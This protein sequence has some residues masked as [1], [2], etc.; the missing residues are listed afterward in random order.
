MYSLI[1]EETVKR[2][3]DAAEEILNKCFGMLMEIKHASDTLGDAIMN[4]QLLL[5]DCLY[6][7]M[8]FY[9][10]LQAEKDFIISQ[11]SKWEQVLFKDAITTNAK[12]LKVVKEVITIGKTLGDAFSWFFYSKNRSE[13]DMHLEHPSTG[14]FVAGVGGKGEIEFIKNNQ[15]I[16]GLFVVYHGITDM[17]RVGDFSLYANGI[18][19]VGIGELKSQREGDRISVTANITSKVNIKTPAEAVGSELSFEERI[20][21]LAKS[22]PSLPKQMEAQDRLMKIKECERSSNFYAD[23]EYDVV[24]SLSPKSPIALNT[25]NSLLLCAAWSKHNSLFDILFDDEHIDA[26]EGLSTYALELMKPESPYNE[27]IIGEI[28][29]Q[30]FFPRMPI[31]WWKI[32]DEL[33]RDIYFKRVSISTVFNPAKLLKLFTDKGFRVVS[34]GKTQDIKLEKVTDGKRMEFGSLQMYMD[35]IHHSMMRTEAVFAIAKRV[36]DE[37]ES[38]KIPSGTKIDMHIHLNN[39]GSMPKE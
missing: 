17:L 33:C 19:I 38:G 13:L 11:K 2:N 14:L 28:D 6:D 3:I 35:L 39:F 36:I 4:F 23:Y 15:T 7:M 37:F 22:F 20:K 9:Q 34:I 25:D 1:S 18:G 8:G 26:P 24:S 12:Y 31:L 10:E 16:D 30:M 5:A 29:T 27:A 21:L 32:S